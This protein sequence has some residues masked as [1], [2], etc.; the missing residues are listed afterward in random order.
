[1]AKIPTVCRYMQ[2][3]IVNNYYYIHNYLATDDF[4]RVL[5][6]N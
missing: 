2:I 1:M 3:T 6:P 4:Y 5:T